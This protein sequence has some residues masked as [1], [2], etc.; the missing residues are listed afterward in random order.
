MRADFGNVDDKVFWRLVIPPP[1][2]D[3]RSNEA[4]RVGHLEDHIFWCSPLEC[5]FA[6]GFGLVFEVE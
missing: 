4:C 3:Q 2:G 5:E 6:H 1:G